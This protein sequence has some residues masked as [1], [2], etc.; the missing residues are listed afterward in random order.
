[1]TDLEVESSERPSSPGRNRPARW[2]RSSKRMPTG[3]SAMPFASWATA[4]MPRTWSK[5]C[6]SALLPPAR[7]ARA[8]SAVGPYLYRSVTNASTDVLR[9]RST[10]AVVREKVG[11][12][13][14]A[15]GVR[16][17][18]KWPKACDGPRPC[19]ATCQRIRPMRSACGVFDGLRLAEIAEVLECPVNTVCSRLRYGFQKLRSLVSRKRGLESWTAESAKNCWITCWSPNRR[20]PRAPRWP[21]ISRDVPV[22]RPNLRG[23]PGVGGHHSRRSIARITGFQATCAACDFG[24]DASALASHDSPAANG[25]PTTQGQRREASRAAVE[26]VKEER[27]GFERLRSL[28][29]V[30]R[31]AS[32]GVDKRPG[33]ARVG[34]AKF[35]NYSFGRIRNMILSHK[36]LSAAAAATATALTACL[37]LYVLSSGRAYALE[38]TVQAN[39]HVTSYHVKITPARPDDNNEVWPQEIWLQL[40]QNGTPLACDRSVQTLPTAPG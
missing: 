8:C 16:A 4:R 38:Q 7:L 35:N 23:P 40:D 18:P 17:L 22:V 37:V 12:A 9:R 5:R 27:L 25:R 19:W 11:V 26:G 31:V 39:S 10:A 1:M 36:R 2:P 28:G 24:A 20:R 14:L 15:G 32:E 3:W 30:E 21:C 33:P 29:R 6:S 34:A 13:E